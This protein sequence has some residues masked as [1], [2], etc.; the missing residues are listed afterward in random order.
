MTAEKAVLDALRGTERDLRADASMV[1][2]RAGKL[3]RRL[4]ARVSDRAWVKIEVAEALSKLAAGI[5]AELAR[6]DERGEQ[7]TAARRA[8]EP[9]TTHCMERHA[10]RLVEAGDSA[11][12]GTGDILKATDTGRRWSWTG[13]EWAP[14]GPGH[15]PGA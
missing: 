1:L 13:K 5:R 4:R 14:F 7:L 10:L 12:M 11:G 6:Q 9:N 3:P 2:D 15:V 8:I